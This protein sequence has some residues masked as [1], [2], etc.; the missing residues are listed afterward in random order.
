MNNPTSFDNNAPIL[1][2]WEQ[3][4]FLAERREGFHRFRLYE[5]DGNYVEVIQH[6]HFNVVLR[7]AS[8]RDP[9][10]LDPYLDAISL[11]GL[12]GC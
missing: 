3:G 12:L 2:V 5:L 7:V 6:S 10:H 9:K 8:F 1:P 11:D 4:V